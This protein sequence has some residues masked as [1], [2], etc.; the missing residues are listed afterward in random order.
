MKIRIPAIF[1]VLLILSGLPSQSRAWNDRGHMTVAYVAYQRL[2]PQTKAR[3]KALLEMNPFHDRWAAAVPAG[4]SEEDKDMIIF[5]LA[6]TW[7]DEIK[8]E[9]GF[10]D[11]GSHGGNRPDGNPNANQ[12]TGFDD[13]Q[14]HKYRH[15][16]DK[17]FSAPDG[18]PLPSI[19]SPNAQDSIA[20]FRAVLASSDPDPLKAYDL[21]WLLHLVGDIHQPLHATTRVTSGL[22]DGDDGGNQV[23]LSCANCPTNLHSFWDDLLGVTTKLQAPPDEKGLPDPPSIRAIIKAAKKLPGANATASAVASEAD[24]A[25][26]SFEAAESSAY[27]GLVPVA[28]GHFSLPSGYRTAA[29]RLA[30]KRIA[31][32]GARLANLLNNELH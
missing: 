13:K 16:I 20:L 12:N 15:F 32:A 18:L 31:L 3:V 2:T 23:K 1:F 25:S 14:K 29:K 6:A 10:I 11:D 7:A 5:M 8:G 27:P 26:E 17:P 30:K 24:W 4:A 21:S 28:N 22:P 9:P 19:P